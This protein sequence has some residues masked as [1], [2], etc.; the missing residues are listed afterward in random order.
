MNFFL[1]ASRQIISIC[2]LLKGL[3][4]IALVQLQLVEG[5]LGAIGWEVDSKCHT[6]VLVSSREL[7]RDAVLID[8]YVIVDDLS[9]ASSA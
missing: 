5:V 4:H 8:A 1:L 9:V 6:C 2:E 7:V 3:Q